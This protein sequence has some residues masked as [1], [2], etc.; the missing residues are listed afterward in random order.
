MAKKKED[1][2]G[3]FAIHTEDKFECPK[4]GDVGSE[5][6]EVTIPPY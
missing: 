5:Q 3:C 1:E 2:L 4:C 6:I